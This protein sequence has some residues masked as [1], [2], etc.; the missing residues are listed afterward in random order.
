MTTLNLS[1][2]ICIPSL[3]M[4]GDF[5]TLRIIDALSEGELRYCDLQRRAGD[6]NPVTLTNRLK[7]LH[8]GGIVTRSEHSRAE[9]VYQLTE[10]GAKV[11]PILDAVNNYSA[12][13]K[14]LS[15]S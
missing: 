6:V 1:N 3:Q 15:A 4:L 2:K 14:K 11:L 13:A 9:V 7:K 12:S 10:L 8:E 5:W